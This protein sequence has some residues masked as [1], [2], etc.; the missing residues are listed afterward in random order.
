MPNNNISSMNLAQSQIK[1]F[2]STWFSTFKTRDSLRLNIIQIFNNFTM[3]V[4]NFSRPRLRTFI[5]ISITYRTVPCKLL[6]N[7]LPTPKIE[8]SAN[9]IFW[10]V[11]MMTY[12]PRYNWSSN[13]KLRRVFVR[14]PEKT[15]AWIES[16][17]QDR[18][19]IIIM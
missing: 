4:C 18:R 16:T 10:Y 19:I 13:V 12:K 17:T 15:S 1:S 6:P 2:I 14:K 7:P 3:K 11:I 9:K 5:T 8:S